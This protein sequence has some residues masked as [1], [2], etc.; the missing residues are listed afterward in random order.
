MKNT[1]T[2]M[3]DLKDIF[4]RVT[5]PRLKFFLKSFY[6]SYI[7]FSFLNL[8]LGANMTSWSHITQSHITD[9]ITSHSHGD[10]IEEHR[11]F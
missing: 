8:G 7:F 9:H 3:R 1:G 4:V 5:K 6:F 2:A 11:R 10:T